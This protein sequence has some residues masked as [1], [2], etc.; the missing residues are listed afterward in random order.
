[1]ASYNTAMI[2]GY[3]QQKYPELPISDS[4]VQNVMNNSSGGD[5]NQL[6]QAI[7]SS[8]QY[9][10]MQATN[11][12][13]AYQ[14]A[15]NT[16]VGGLQTQKS[17]LANQYSDLLKT[18][19]GEYTPLIN[20]ATAT[21]GQQE[22]QRGISPDSALYQQQ[23][24]GALQPV[25]GQEAG[26]AQTIGAGSIADVNSLTQAIANIQAGGA[27][28]ASQLPLQYGSLSLSQQALPSQIAA[29]QAQANQ[30]NALAQASKYLP[31]SAGVSFFN[32][33]NQTVSNPAL[34]ILKQLGYNLTA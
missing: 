2:Q 27:G 15:I 3:I 8:P 20:Q 9:Q 6:D 5:P 21:A 4:F 25:Y 30:A 10:Q 33:S 26:A 34:Q 18:V 22:A 28:T 31:A 1:M 12:S 32:T 24:Q 19:T 16:A 14:G 17:N 23:V 7:T 11:A 29:N 13:N